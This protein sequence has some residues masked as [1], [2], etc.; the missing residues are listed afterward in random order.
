MNTGTAI[1]RSETPT[2][3]LN[4][5]VILCTYNR[6]QSL[7]RALES[8]ARSVM[9]SSVQW[10]VLVI[11]N[12]SK[13]QTREVIEGY[14]QRFPHIFRYV[15]EAKQGKSYALNTGIRLAGGDVLAFTD[16]DLA[17][18]SLW[19]ENLTAPLRSAGWAGA[20]GRVLPEHGFQPQRWMDTSGRY[21]LAPLA[22]FEPSIPAGKIDEPPFGANMAYR[23]E[24][25]SKH[26]GF[27]L[28]LGPEAGGEI[29][30]ED[31]EFGARILAAGEQIWYEPSAVVYHEVPRHR[32]RKSYFL[33]W[34]YGKGRSDKRLDDSVDRL[35]IFGVPLF[36]LRRLA[37]WTLRWVFSF[38]PAQRFRCKAKVWYIAGQLKESLVQYRNAVPVALSEPNGKS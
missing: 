12:N 24:M 4:T 26:G 22:M 1:S 2:A 34:W 28:D 7:A 8:L 25:F 35:S 9:P 19:L 30:N 38:Y 32:A 11:D 16:D 37:V 31:V 18:D 5:T 20:G 15:F 23:K 14:C 13:D 10:E 27:R 29:K 36:L 21:G 33:T 17:V 6:Y 3:P